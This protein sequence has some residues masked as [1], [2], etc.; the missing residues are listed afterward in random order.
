MPIQC[1]LNLG[2]KS[3][4]KY[5][6][7]SVK[8][9]IKDPIANSLSVNNNLKP[10]ANSPIGNNNDNLRNPHTVDLLLADYSELID[11]RYTPW[12]AKRFYAMPFELIHRCA[13]EARQDG[14]NSQRLFAFLI[15][16]NSA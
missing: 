5:T 8:E 3:S 16:K 10:I 12:F 1:Y 7:S 6:T 4:M 15:K 11:K 14:K 9:I 2:R 13:S